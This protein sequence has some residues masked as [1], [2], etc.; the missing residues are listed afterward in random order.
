[1]YFQGENCKL[2]ANYDNE[3][4]KGDDNDDDAE[5]N[6]VGHHRNYNIRVNRLDVEAQ[7]NLT[8]ADFFL[9][10]DVNCLFFF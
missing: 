10:F 3:R 6:S 7:K 4:D 5:K 2:D 1:M 8:N 9:S